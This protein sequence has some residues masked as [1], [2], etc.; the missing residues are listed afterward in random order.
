MEQ[1]TGPIILIV[2][3]IL[4]FAL[5]WAR[6]LVYGHRTAASDDAMKLV[7]SIAGTVCLVIGVGGAV[8][9]GLFILAPLGLLIV[10]AVAIMLITRY[11]T[12]ERRSLLRCLSVAA[13]KG[14]TAQRSNT[15]ICE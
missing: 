13:E 3:V 8:T 7:L 10:S 11:R 14:C 1:I 5:F 4:G 2:L 15:S 6:H 9:H 12:L